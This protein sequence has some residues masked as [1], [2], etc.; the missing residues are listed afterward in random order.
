[1]PYKFHMAL[2][3][4]RGTPL[5]SR[6]YVIFSTVQ[7][8]SLPR[9]SVNSIHPYW[10]AWW[11]MAWWNDKKEENIN[12]DKHYWLQYQIQSDWTEIQEK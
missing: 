11:T 10:A 7:S 4:Y 9:S 1:M 2:L 3:D 12:M 5:I 6:D 8:P